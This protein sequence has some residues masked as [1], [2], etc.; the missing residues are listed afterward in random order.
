MLGLGYSADLNL[1]RKALRFFSKE[2]LLRPYAP[3]RVVFNAADLSRLGDG[4]TTHP[5]QFVLQVFLEGISPLFRAAEKQP[6]GPAARA[7]PMY[8]SIRLLACL[9]H[10]VFSR[11]PGVF[12]RVQELAHRQYGVDAMSVTKAEGIYFLVAKAMK[13]TWGYDVEAVQPDNQDF[14]RTYLHPYRVQYRSLVARCLEVPG[15]WQRL[16]G[17]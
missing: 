3:V 7:A 17:L 4:L 13:K 14:V 11:N 15:I 2:L 6:R 12:Q 5:L 16:L 10:E 1:Q 8:T 9:A